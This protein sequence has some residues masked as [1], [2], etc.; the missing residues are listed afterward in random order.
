MR[1][2]RKRLLAKTYG[3]KYKRWNDGYWSLTQL[4]HSHGVSSFK[5]MTSVELIARLKRY[6]RMNDRIAKKTKRIRQA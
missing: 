3:Y 2:L 1:T 5:P 4:D 6:K